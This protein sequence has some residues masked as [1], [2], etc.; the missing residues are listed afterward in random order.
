MALVFDMEDFADIDTAKNAGGK[1]WENKCLERVKQKIKDN[2]INDDTSQ[3]CY[4]ARSFKGEFRMVIDIEH[5]LPQS[6]FSTERFEI[7]NL[8]VAC[9]RCN[10]EIK[11]ADTSFINSIPN[12]GVNYYHSQH[13]KLI[14]P[15]LDTY[16]DHIVVKTARTGN[17]IINKYVYKNNLKG[18][19]TYEYFRLA[20]LEIDTINNAQGGKSNSTISTLISNRIRGALI[21]LLMRI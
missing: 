9:K 12:M 10:M 3:C 7:Q 4:C 2:F 1:I 6:V 15:N 17:S 20:E 19:Y 14:H 16:T 13:Y 18:K 8:N 5:I 21:T 11:R